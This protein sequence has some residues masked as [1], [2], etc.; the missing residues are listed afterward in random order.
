[1]TSKARQLADLGGDTANL[2]DVSS[3]YGSGALSNRNLIINGAMQVAQ[4]GTSATGVTGTGYYVCDRW[5]VDAAS[6]DDTV[7]ISQSTD[8]PDAFANSYKV[9]VTTGDASPTSTQEW[10]VR[11]AIEAQNLQHLKYGTASATSATLSFWVKSSVAGTYAVEVYCNDGTR[12]L[13][14]TYTINSANTWEYKTHTFLGDTAGTINND[15]GGGLNINYYLYAGADLKS[16]ESTSWKAY[17][18]AGKA[19]GQVANVIGTTGAT[20]QITGVQLEV[21]DTAT[22]FEH[23]SYGQELALCQRYFYKIAAA[24]AS[25]YLC[26]GFS[27][28]STQAVALVDFPVTMRSAPTVSRANIATNTQLRHTGGTNN[29]DTDT[30]IAGVPTIQGA[31]VFITTSGIAVGSGFLRAAGSTE[32]S[33]SFDSEL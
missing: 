8:A 17:T 32:I 19:Y 22:P 13:T 6:T 5:K 24:G 28:S 31:S 2:E 33:F 26:D 3:A 21:G 18:S 10:Y 25:A 16:T 1:M 9:E 11:Q 15:T 7:T 23:R 4:R 30:G 12:H 29:L 27:T 14:F 20:W